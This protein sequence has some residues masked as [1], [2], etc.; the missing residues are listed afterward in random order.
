MPGAWGLLL[1]GLLPGLPSVARRRWSHRLGPKG[2]VTKS[3]LTEG[4]GGGAQDPE[5]QGGSWTQQKCGIKTLTPTHHGRQ[6][7]RG[8]KASPRCP[9][10]LPEQTGPACPFAEFT[11]R[12][13]KQL[14]ACPPGALLE[15]GLPQLSGLPPKSPASLWPGPLQPSPRWMRGGAEGAF[16]GSSEKDPEVPTVTPAPLAHLPGPHLC[17]LLGPT[18]SWGRG[19]Y[20]GMAPPCPVSGL[21]PA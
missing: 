11:L 7:A 14:P 10:N 20:A 5:N 1:P 9:R 15:G 2:Q 4:R 13:C 8:V 3:Q 6:G 17:S 21:Q 19:A 16:P 18:S 12:L